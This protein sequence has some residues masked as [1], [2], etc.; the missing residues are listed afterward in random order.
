MFFMNFHFA[1]TALENY[2][3]HRQQSC[4]IPPKSELLIDLVENN[5]VDVIVR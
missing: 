4:E 1:F 2:R 3:H 5:V